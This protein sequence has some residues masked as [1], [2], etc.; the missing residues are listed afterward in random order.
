VR[1]EVAAFGN[2]TAAE[3]RAIADEYIDLNDHLAELRLAK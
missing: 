3:L 2:S 1:V